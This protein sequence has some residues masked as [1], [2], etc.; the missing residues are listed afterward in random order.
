MQ[1]DSTPIGLNY[2]MLP[3]SA[4]NPLSKVVC[5]VESDNTV[6]AC[7]HV[8]A[9]HPANPV[10]CTFTTDS[11]VTHSGICDPN[12]KCYAPTQTLT[13]VMHSLNQIQTGFW[14]TDLD[15]FHAF[16][17]LFNTMAVLA[18]AKGALI[19]TAVQMQLI[20]LGLG[21]GQQPM[22]PVP[23]EVLR[24]QAGAFATWLRDRY[25]YHTNASNFVAVTQQ[26]SSQGWVP[27]MQARWSCRSDDVL[28][29]ID[30]TQ[31]QVRMR[32]TGVEIH[33]LLSNQ[34]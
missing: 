29:S 31:L 5:M 1:S 25:S 24:I 15:L 13:D 22:A 26:A 27:T 23:T 17:G 6:D 30:M 14:Q 20:Y 10:P 4:R 11:G 18:Y 16:D 21:S 28:A 33:A 9:W 12:Q 8:G 3:P 19:W 34:R 32:M 2:T 7:A